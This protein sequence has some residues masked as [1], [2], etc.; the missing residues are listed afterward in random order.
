[1]H[2]AVCHGLEGRGDGPAAVHL[3]PPAHDFGTGAFRLVSTRNGV[4]SDADLIATLRHGMP[5]S[6]MPSWDWL[7]DDDLELLAAHVRGLAAKGMAADLEAAGAEPDEAWETAWKRLQPA[8][9]LSLVEPAVVSEEVLARG[10]ELYGANCTTCHG[11]D[12]SGAPSVP[13]ARD[14]TAGFLRGGAAH[15][16]LAARI[17]CGLP[18]TVMPATELGD[19]DLAALIAHVQSLIPSGSTGRYVLE[20]RR[21]AAHKVAFPVP[22]R[23][24]D[25]RWDDAAEIEVKLAPLRW[26]G[27]AVL[28]ARLAAVHDGR[29]IA[30]RVRWKDGTRESQLLGDLLAADAV[31]LQL[32]V[33]PRPPLFG[34]G[35][36]SNPTNL[37]YWK[38]AR[39]EDV[40]GSLD[41]LEGGPHRAV[42]PRFGE[43]RLDGPVYRPFEGVPPVAVRGDEMTATGV[44]GARTAERRRDDVQVFPTSNEDGWDVV[45]VRT[46]A[47]P[48]DRDLAFRAPEPVQ[49]AVA[50]WNGAA[51]DRGAQK[52]I[53]IWQELRLLP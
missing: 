46:L 47:A 39:L 11:P 42:D 45:F 38:S 31:A 21:F 25:S 44:E 15:D 27:E 50:V 8:R 20:R 17:R 1:M 52:S 51:G 35:S 5:G 23:A 53:S 43:V 36:E 19:E 3:D 49:V 10:A 24:D 22:D 6:S 37:W 28:S 18:G 34:M 40:A 4:P 7:E 41:L 29:S 33:S 48:T 14:F 16:E 13:A 26:H 32:S 2:C 12:G 30:L 9:P